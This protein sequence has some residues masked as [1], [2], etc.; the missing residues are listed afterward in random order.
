[1]QKNVKF[2]HFLGFRGRNLP[3]FSCFG[4]KRKFSLFFTFFHVFFTFLG[5]W[6]VEKRVTFWVGSKKWKK[7]KK[8]EKKWKFE[9]FLSYEWGKTGVVSERNLWEN[10][11]GFGKKPRNFEKNVFSALFLTFFSLFSRFF[12]V[13]LTFLGE[14]M[15][16]G[17][18]NPTVGNRGR[19]H[20]KSEK[21]WKKLK[22]VKK[23]EKKWKFDGS[24]TRFLEK[25]ALKT[26]HTKTCENSKKSE[27]KW[28]KREKSEKNMKKSENFEG[29]GGSKKGS[30]FRG[31]SMKKVKKSEN[32]EKK[33]KKVKKSALDGI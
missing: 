1:M 24:R 18:P 30:L 7:V 9:G 6:R 16:S 29:P 20:E 15:G 4:S 27:K 3:H 13:F 10:H 11:V 5:V 26:E 21:K 23:S 2:V 25:H 14:K 17:F 12:H 22:K 8:S 33:W 28:K 31:K 32:F 19:E